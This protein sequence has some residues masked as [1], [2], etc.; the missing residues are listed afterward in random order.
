MSPCSPPH[1]KKLLQNQA[2]T[3]CIS[4]NRR[5]HQF[6]RHTIILCAAEKET[7]TMKLW[8]ANIWKMHPNFKMNE[9]RR[10]ERSSETQTMPGSAYMITKCL[11]CR[12][13]RRVFPSAVIPPDPREKE[14]MS[15]IGRMLLIITKMKNKN[16]FSKRCFCFNFLSRQCLK[17]WHYK[18]QHV[19]FLFKGS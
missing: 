9:G 12:K 19:Q 16:W 10:C 15:Y 2:T 1:P 5:H 7:L 18:V 3:N 6:V 17:A 4:S 8:H 13:E 11:V 14:N